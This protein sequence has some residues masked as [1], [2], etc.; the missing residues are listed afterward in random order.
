[1]E[2]KVGLC[3][4]IFIYARGNN[5]YNKGYDKNKESSFLRYCDI[6][7]KY[8]WVISQ[9]RPV[10]NFEWVKDTSQINEDLMIKMIFEVNDKYFKK[11]HEINNHLSFL[12]ESKH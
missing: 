1:M 7:N 12:P 10:N 3:H 8:G 4:S 6:N 9:K 5:K 2:E 11:I